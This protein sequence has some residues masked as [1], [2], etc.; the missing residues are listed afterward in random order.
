MGLDLCHKV[1][2]PKKLVRPGWPAEVASTQLILLAPS[3]Y[4]SLPNSA[5][6]S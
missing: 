6:K 5:A 4:D 1:A 2:N 3:H